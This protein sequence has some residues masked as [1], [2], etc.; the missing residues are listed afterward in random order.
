MFVLAW[1]SGHR[2]PRTMYYR[3]SKTGWGATEQIAEARRFRSEKACITKWRSKLA[4]PDEPHYVNAVRSGRVRAEP[5]T[6][7]GLIL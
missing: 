5:L 2:P 3:E 6:Q 7:P 1:T 4:F